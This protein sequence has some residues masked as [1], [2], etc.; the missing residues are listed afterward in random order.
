MRVKKWKMDRLTGSLLFDREFA[1]V[2]SSGSALRLNTYPKM[3]FIQPI[4]DL[5]HKVLHVKAPDC[6]E[7]T[8]NTSTIACGTRLINSCDLEEIILAP[9][10]S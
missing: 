1:L 6:E 4:V 3:G 8:L 10:I 2:D 9:S 5:E 7:P